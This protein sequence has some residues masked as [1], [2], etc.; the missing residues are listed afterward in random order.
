MSGVNTGVAAR[1]AAEEKRAL[2]T[3]CLA[4]S[5]NFAAQDATKSNSFIGDVLVAIQ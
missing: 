5:L 3:K 1:I 4:H 2:N